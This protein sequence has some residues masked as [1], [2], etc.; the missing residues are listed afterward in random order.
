MGVGER[1][2]GWWGVRSGAEVCVVCE[3]GERGVG[4]YGLF[5][6]RGWVG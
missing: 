5:S 6:R 4:G 1:D 2:A 3:A